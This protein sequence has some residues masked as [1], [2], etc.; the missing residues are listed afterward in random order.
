M[1]KVIS[2]KLIPSQVSNRRAIKIPFL[3]FLVP[4]EVLLSVLL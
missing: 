4:A 1:L 2:I 3:S